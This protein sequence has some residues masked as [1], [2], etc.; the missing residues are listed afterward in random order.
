[1]PKL[2]RTSLR[3]GDRRMDDVNLDDFWN[4]DADKYKC[5]CRTF[6]V[7]R[8]SLF[9]AYAQMLITFVFALFFTFYYIQAIN[10]RLLQDHW[11]NQLGERYI[12]SLLFAVTLQLLLVLLLV[13]GIR[14]ERRSFLLPFI[15][16][17]LIA[18]LLG[19][20][21]I[22]NDLFGFMH[23]SSLAHLMYDNNQFFSHLIGTLFQLWCV[24]TVWRCYGFLGDKKVVRHIGE[25]LSTTQMAFHYDDIP[26]EY[27]TMSQPPPY[28]D[29][30]IS[31]DKEPLTT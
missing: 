7:V 13:H 8:A 22:G 18:V 28:A 11:I 20:I 16:F 23:P 10:G 9:I 25:Q 5:C 12:S 29:T 1:M 6:H 2:T 19:F 26:H 15:V 31:I 17:S 3:G 14:T 27:I 24:A 4:A 30:V 21:Q